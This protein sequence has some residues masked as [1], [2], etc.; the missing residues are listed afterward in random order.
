MNIDGC[1]TLACLSRIDRDAAK[2]VKIYPL[3]NTYVVKDLVPG[4]IQ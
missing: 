1:N 2:T 3:P 4:T